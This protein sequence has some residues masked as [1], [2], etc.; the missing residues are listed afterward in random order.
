MWQQIL[1]DLK[2]EDYKDGYYHISE[3]LKKYPDAWVYVKWSLRDPG[4][5]YRG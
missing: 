5:T 2:N 3:D 1:E 4:K